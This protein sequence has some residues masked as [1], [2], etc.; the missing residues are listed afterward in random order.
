MFPKQPEVQQT[1]LREP[2]SLQG[3]KILVVDDNETNRFLVST[4]VKSWGCAL[5]EAA[6]GERA[7]EALQAAAQAGSPF[8]IAV[9]DMIMPGMDGAEL[10]RRIKATPELTNTHMVLLTSMGERGDARRMHTIGF[11]AYLRKPVRQGQLRECLALVMGMTP[12]GGA[13]IAEP[14]L[15]TRHVAEEARKRN[16]RILLAE[17]NPVNQMVALDMLKKLGYTADVVTTGKE[18]I[19]ALR[20]KPYDLVLMDCQMPEMDGFETVTRIRAGQPG[21]SGPDVPVVAVTAHAMKGDR[22]RCIASGMNDYISKPLQRSELAQVLDRW[23][24]KKTA[25][26]LRAAHAFP[27]G[28]SRPG[29]GIDSRL[30]FDRDALLDRLS[31]DEAFLKDII[32]C[33]I[34]QVPPQIQALLSAA[35]AGDA[36]EA[37][38]LAHTISGAA[39]NVNSQVVSEAASAI[40]SA[41]KARRMKDVDGLVLELQQ[42]VNALTRMMAD[43]LPEPSSPQ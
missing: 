5:E 29:A 18:A 6:D 15:I 8:D 22:D 4:L 23:L 13:T 1:V 25:P 7:L 16:S 3:V 35:T 34:A 41:A 17:D 28:E 42:A 43:Q 38:H 26:P 20:Q 32:E 21:A 40:E 37:E 27:G 11:A 12:T 2:A 31:G 19:E 36:R 39:A 30:I 10:G 24:S 14:S 9:I 33:F